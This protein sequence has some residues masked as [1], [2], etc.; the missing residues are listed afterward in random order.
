VCLSVAGH[1]APARYSNTTTV[2]RLMAQFTSSVNAPAGAAVAAASVQPTPAPASA[3]KRAREPAGACDSIT[4]EVRSHALEDGSASVCGLCG[5][6]H[7]WLAWLDR[8]R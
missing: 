4:I 3:R 6:A 7:V 8:F 1:E 2:A 5:T